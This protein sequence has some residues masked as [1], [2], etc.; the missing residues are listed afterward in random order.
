MQIIVSEREGG[1]LGIRAESLEEAA[2]I[3][4][5]VKHVKEASDIGPELEILRKAKSKKR[6]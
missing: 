6:K 4:L 2:Q 1:Y 3:L 5:L